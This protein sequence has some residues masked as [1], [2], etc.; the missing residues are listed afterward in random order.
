MEEL[1]LMIVQ[2]GEGATKVIRIDI[3]GGRS[4][5]DAIHAA[6][7]VANSALVKT[8]FYGQDPNWGRIMAALGRAEITMDERLVDIWINDT[9]IVSEGLGM[10]AEMEAKAAEIMTQ[11]ELT[12][13]IDLHQGDYQDHTFTCDLTHKYIDINADYRT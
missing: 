8:A 9:Q 10:G 6:R 5:K 7:T 4:P 3:K 2:D 13:T 11:K 1:A 12:L